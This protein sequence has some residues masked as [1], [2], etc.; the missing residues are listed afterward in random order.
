M[1][2]DG[3]APYPFGSTMRTEGATRE[4]VEV[5]SVRTAIR[6]FEAVAEHQ[7]VGLSELS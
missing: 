2:A 6:V 7:P 5:K 1:R 3:R 4:D